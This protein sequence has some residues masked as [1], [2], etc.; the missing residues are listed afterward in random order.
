MPG[1][2]RR[3]PNYST[4]EI[5]SHIHE[6]DGDFA[7]SKYSKKDMAEVNGWSEKVFKIVVNPDGSED[8]TLTNPKTGVIGVVRI[9]EPRL[10]SSWNVVTTA[11]IA[12]V[13]LTVIVACIIFF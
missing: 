2:K 8:I 10:M 11:S 6:F 1:R 7:M 9:K 3:S 13:A 4:A 12:A 5:M